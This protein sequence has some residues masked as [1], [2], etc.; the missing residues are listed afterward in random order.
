MAVK[1]IVLHQTAEGE[2]LL[3]EMEINWEQYVRINGVDCADGYSEYVAVVAV[4]DGENDRYMS[5]VTQH[6][7]LKYNVLH[8]LRNVLNELTDDQ[9]ELKGPISGGK[10]STSD[11]AR[12]LGRAGFEVQRWSSRLR[13]Y[14]SSFWGGQQ[15]QPGDDTWRK[16]VGPEDR[17]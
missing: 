15:E 17:Q 12:G 10:A 2:Q 16:A 4:D 9:L 13:D 3:A 8:L 5:V 6:E 11:L 14:R 7:R 1:V